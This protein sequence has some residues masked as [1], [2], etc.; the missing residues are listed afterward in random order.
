M[1]ML[2]TGEI[3]VGIEW[4][5]VGAEISLNIDFLLISSVSHLSITIPLQRMSFFLLTSILFG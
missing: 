2:E 3:Q 1:V 5:P 4:I